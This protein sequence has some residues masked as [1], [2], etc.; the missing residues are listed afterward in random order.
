M[1]G[2]PRM[3]MINDLIE[4][5]YPPHVMKRKAENRDDWRIWRPRTCP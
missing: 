3:G 4:E 5:S 1:R 2:R